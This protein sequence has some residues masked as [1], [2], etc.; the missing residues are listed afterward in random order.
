MNATLSPLGRAALDYAARG[1]H[2]LVLAERSKIPPEGSHGLDDATTDPATITQW[3]TATPKANIGINCAASRVVV[4]DV[5]H[6]HDDGEA[7]LAALVAELG[8]LPETIEAITGGG[9]RHLVFTA[10]D[11]AKFRGKLGPGVD[12]R[13]H[14][15]IAVAPSVHPDTGAVYRWV[16]SPLGGMPAPLPDAWIARMV[17][18]AVAPVTN[19]PRTVPSTTGGSAYGRKAADDEL[20]RVRTEP[21][22]DRNNQT[23][24]SALALG[25]LFA[26]GEIGDVRDDLIAAAMSA[27]LPESEARKTVESG[28][29]AG[30]AQPRPAPP[31]PGRNI[32]VKTTSKTTS[33]AIAASPATTETP[34]EVLPASRCLATVEPRPV[35]WLWFGRLAS[36]EM[37]VLTGPPGAGKGLLIVYI[38]SRFTTGRP[39][40]GD[41]QACPAGHV[42]YVSVEDDDSTALVP[43]HKAAGTDLDRVHSWI[44]DAPPTLP[45]DTERIVTEIDRVDAEIL[46]LDPAP[47]LLTREFSS[48]SDADV[49][50][51]YSALAAA[52]RTRGV[53]LI[54]V[55]HTNKRQLGDAMAR[56]GGSIGWSGMARI[57]LMLG[58]RPPTDGATVDNVDDASVILAPV[59][60]NL[61]KWPRSL[62]ARIVEAG[63]SAR[64]EF[65]GVSDATAD[66]LCA[67][68]RPRMARKSGDAEALLRRVLND[69]E[70]HAQRE[71][72]EEAKAA[73]ISYRTLARAKADLGVQSRQRARAW[74]W[75]LPRQI[76]MGAL[77]GT[78]ATWQPENVGNLTS[79]SINTLESSDS[80]DARLPV[81]HP[82]GA[83]T[84]PD[85]LAQLAHCL[86]VKP[87]SVVSDTDRAAL[88]GYFHGLN[89]NANEV[90]GRL[91]NYWRAAAAPT[92]SDFLAREKGG[93]HA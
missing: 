66:D 83:L 63:D 28:W 6:H 3:W 82:R 25:S 86:R 61:G 39:M 19:R 8:P 80:Q 73:D 90:A 89:G 58:R 77:S 72:D 78:L 38:V 21:Q 12:L 31:K 87:E 84:Q 68:D 64:M 49:R 14:A 55:R 33:T 70:W 26:G 48:N 20:A 24:K 71:I 16:R 93:A 35:K 85:P 42:L 54:L 59:K 46:I 1:Y 75:R 29:R 23:N 57:E 34:A 52:C 81:T 17:K 88:V 76:A 7:T 15:Y 45:D 44:M 79:S 43:R 37:V 41:R 13:H 50:R 69:G 51:A 30:L 56:G 10:P 18:P 60:S 27:G 2:V 65:L 11:G 92:V 4:I 47:T 62:H 40:E 53:A 5:D 91:F 67:Q 22:G 36:G 32:M 9:G 74:E